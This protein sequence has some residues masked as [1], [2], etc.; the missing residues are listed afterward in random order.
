MFKGFSARKRGFT[1]VELLVVIAI[2]G[3][4]VG[5]LLPAVQAA[6]E[7]AR[8]MQCSNNLKQLGLALHNF[9]SANKKIPASMHSP[10]W[11]A[12]YDDTAYSYVGHLVQL[13]PYMEQ[14]Q[15]YSPHAANCDL[16]AA[17]YTQPVT[18]PPNLRR[19]A[20]YYDGTGSVVVRGGPV[21][22]PDIM[23]V[24]T[25]KIPGLLCPSDSPE[26][27]F[28]A[29][30]AGLQYIFTVFG[31]F[32]NGFP[33][34]GA[35]GMNDQLGRPVSRDCAPTNYVGVMGRL[36]VASQTYSLP[37]GPQALAIDTY[38]GVFRTNKDQKLSIMSDGTS[39]TV[40][41]GEVT[42][43]FTDG[44]KASGRQFSFC[45]NTSAL[46]IHYNTLSFSTGAAYNNAVKDWSRFS[47]MHTGLVQWTLGDGSVKS[48]SINT[49]PL[50]ML[51]L[52]GAA[53]GESVD[54]SVIQ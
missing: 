27:A 33:D 53:D 39:N 9:E 54:G 52:G 17:T 16:N 36:P 18:T 21:A 32:R 24:S 8:R 30:G 25:A 12:A 15:V 5:L 50:V 45:W 44:L 20:W 28:V 29:E 35:Y 13:F 7:A 37:A 10:D 43:R 49:D 19:R 31:R 3:I 40:L 34:F 38:A 2:I 11:N 22:Y 47:S 26:N 1:L 23:A 42:G 46:P 4:L 14:T 6:R 41:F 51:R 48:L